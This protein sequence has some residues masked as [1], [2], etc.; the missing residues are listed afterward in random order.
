MKFSDFGFEENPFAITPDPRYLYLSRGHEESLAHLIYGTGP[1]GGFVL[2]TGEVGTGKTL[3]LRSLLAQQL[4]NVEIALILNP[5]LSRR[6]F[7][8]T[9]CD[10]LG[11][12][13]QGPPYSLKILIDTLTQ[14]LLKI[15][16]EGKHTVL[17]VD[18]AQ[19][20]NPRV[21]EQVRLLTNLETSRHKLLRIILVGQPELQQMLAR[22]EMRQVDQRITA[23]YHLSPLNAQETHRYVTHRLAVAGVRED[24]F[25]PSALHLVHRLSGGIPRIINSICERSLLAIYTTG[26]QRVGMRLVWRAAQEVKGRRNHRHRWL[27]AGALLLLLGGGVY[28]YSQLGQDQG[29]VSIEQATS[30]EP[31]IPSL[32]PVAEKKVAIELPSLPVKEVVEEKLPEPLPEKVAPNLSQS[33]PLSVESSDMLEPQPPKAAPGQMMDDT[34]PVEISLERL[35]NQPQNSFIIHQKLLTLW[36]KSQPLRPTPPPCLQVTEFGL[37]CLKAHLDWDGVLHLNRPLLIQLKQ[38]KLK[39]L[40]LVNHVDDEWLLVDSGEQQGVLRLAQLKSYWTGDFIMLWR[41]LAGVALIGEGSAGSAV[42]WLRKRLQLID[43]EEL[44]KTEGLDRFDSALEGRLRAFQRLYGLED[45]GI[46]GQQTQIHLN[47]LALPV[48]TPTLVSDLDQVGD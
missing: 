29:A 11:V 6:E 42:T 13:Y 18:E 44:P 32:P 17:V 39:R 1:N 20:L 25:T 15:H 38:G 47:N 36:D 3:L 16:A 5:R 22:K 2:L 41:P 34:V 43:G 45:D 46:A 26:K 31:A 19:N 35:F 23:R 33:P 14:R 28:W 4:E 8:A 21:L 48:E 40:L 30:P 10:E 24:L 7:I 9:I 12:V 37:R 27:W